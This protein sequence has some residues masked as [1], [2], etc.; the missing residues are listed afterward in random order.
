M[1]YIHTYIIYT[2][3]YKQFFATYN[4]YLFSRKVNFLPLMVPSGLRK[5]DLF[6]LKMVATK[7]KT[8]IFT[9][10]QHL[11]KKIRTKKKNKK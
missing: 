1:I 3:E 4:G 8:F 11:S 10:Q 6:K 5:F 9:T 2:I 7:R